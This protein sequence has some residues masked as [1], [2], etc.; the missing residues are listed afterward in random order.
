MAIAKLRRVRIIFPRLWTPNDKGKY[1]CNVLIQK[2]SPAYQEI[3]RA[4]KE[5]WT[6]GRDKFGADSFCQN[7]TMAQL[8]NRAYVKFE[9][10]LDSRG[11]Q[12]RNITRGA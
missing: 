5:A 7:P 3:M 2:D 9:G 8:L 12:C 11:I 4:M 6:A 10:G 1:L